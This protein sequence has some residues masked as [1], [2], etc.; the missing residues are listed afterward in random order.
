MGADSLNGREPY[1][2]LKDALEKVPV[3]PDNRIDELLPLRVNP[4]SCL[5]TC[6]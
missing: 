4:I 6:R 2:S 5:D 3:W 1:A